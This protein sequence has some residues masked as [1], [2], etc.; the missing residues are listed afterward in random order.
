MANYGRNRQRL[1]VNGELS[2]PPHGIISR[3]SD[4]ENIWGEKSDEDLLEAAAQLSDFTDEGQRVIRAELRRRGMEDPVEQAGE[5]AREVAASE[6]EEGGPEKAE[7]DQP[8]EALPEPKC[9]RCE[10]EMRYR[11]AR[12][13]LG[14][15]GNLFESADVFDV[16]V[17]PKCGHVEMFANETGG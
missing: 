10:A 13:M 9:L 4:M 2:T 14:E 17:C 16:Y 12:T 7:A 3:M 6:P 1:T 5:S 11:G 15:T 8:G